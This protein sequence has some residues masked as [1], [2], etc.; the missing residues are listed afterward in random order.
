MKIVTNT[1]DKI[2]N[3]GAIALLPGEAHE[4][5]AEFENNA[6]VQCFER[7]G[8]LKI[9][10]DGAEKAAAEAKAAQKAAETA[11]KA[12]K[13]KAEQDAKEKAEAEEASR[14]Q[15]AEAKAKAKAAAE[16]KDG[17]K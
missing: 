10:D 15:A 5:P 11:E 16:A 13:E 8:L 6:P 2:I 4:L 14:K 3:V 17:Q 7:M 1:S 12:A 9:V